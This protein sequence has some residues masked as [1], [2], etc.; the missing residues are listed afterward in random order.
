MAGRRKQKERAMGIVE[1]LLVVIVISGFLGMLTLV[2]NSV[3]AQSADQQTRQTLSVLRSALVHYH[4]SYGSWPPGHT[5][6]ALSALID[7]PRDDSPIFSLSVIVED[8]GF[9]VIRDAFGNDVKYLPPRGQKD[10]DFVSAG[11]DGEFGN[12]LAQTPED[13]M[14]LADNIY[15]RETER[16]DR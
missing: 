11:P 9:Y 10:P 1:L 7:Q 8:K 13:R 15:G 16:R 12:H 3:R 2:T 4:E 14:A 6:T 5:G